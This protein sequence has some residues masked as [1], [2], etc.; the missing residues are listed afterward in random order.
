M[1]E[2]QEDAEPR[3]GDM[4][5]DSV[6]K[7]E[8]ILGGQFKTGEEVPFFGISRAEYP[9]LDVAAS[10]LLLIQAPFLRWEQTV[11]SNQARPDIVGQPHQFQVRTPSFFFCLLPS[12]GGRG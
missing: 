6:F 11:K 4:V 1:A 2:V 12:P 7:E 5:D 8:L 10:Q 3:A 9:K